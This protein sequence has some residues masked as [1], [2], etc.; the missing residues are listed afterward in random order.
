MEPY[1]G[2][3]GWWGMAV[4]L[5]ILLMLMGCGTTSTTGVAQYPLPVD[6]LATIYE[7]NVLM[8]DSA[9]THLRWYCEW[10]PS[11]FWFRDS[12]DS[13]RL[14]LHIR[15]IRGCDDFVLMD[16]ISAVKAFEFSITGNTE[17]Y[18][19]KRHEMLDY[20]NRK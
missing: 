13:V 17:L 14:L 7:I 8:N 10:G 2:Q 5:P 11:I 20:Y 9:M 3:A 19:T 6:R 15:D 16:H 4:L 18:D 12:Q 1:H